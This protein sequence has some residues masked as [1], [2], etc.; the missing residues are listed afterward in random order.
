MLILKN[1][2]IDALGQP[3]LRKYIRGLKSDGQLNTSAEWEPMF[4]K[5]INGQLSGYTIADTRLVA[6]QRRFPLAGWQLPKVGGETPK[7]DPKPAP[8]PVVKPTP[9]VKPAPVDHGA[10][11]APAANGGQLNK[12][13]IIASILNGVTK[14][15]CE[16]ICTAIIE[17]RIPDGLPELKIIIREAKTVK[18]DVPT[19]A[20]FPRLLRYLAAGEDVYCFGP[21]GTGKTEMGKQLALALDLNFY[22]TSKISAEHHFQGFVDGAGTYHETPFFKAFTRG[23]L[24]LFDEMDASNP[25]V[26]TRLNAAL[27]NRRCD[28]PHGIFEAHKDFVCLGAGNTGLGGASREYNARQQ[29]DSALVDR[30]LFVPVGYDEKLER[31][32]A[33]TFPNGL[34]AAERVQAVRAAVK[35]LKIRHTVSMRATMKLAKLLAVGDTRAEAEEAALWKNLDNAAITKIEADVK[36]NA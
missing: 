10:K 29:Q 31:S 7:A 23:G 35:R 36:A 21:A 18:I 15:E 16:A 6:M 13:E 24:F 17:A 33:A 19:H 8:M 14:E 3:E 20:V 4:P 32:I 12:A 28:F 9:V 27:A 2:E 25:N 26:L 5:W 1:S 30:F 11:P 34:T 22:F